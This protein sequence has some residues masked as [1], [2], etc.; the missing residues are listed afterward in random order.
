MYMHDDMCQF[1]SAKEATRYFQFM[2]YDM[3]HRRAIY[4]KGDTI[5]EGV[6]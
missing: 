5:G 2:D 4:H 3:S 1:Q 6:R